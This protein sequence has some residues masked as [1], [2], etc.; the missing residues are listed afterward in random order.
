[1]SGIDLEVLSSRRGFNGA[2]RFIKKTLALAGGEVNLGDALSGVDDDL[3]GR[4]AL[5]LQVLLVEKLG[6]KTACRNLSSPAG[7]LRALG[8]VFARW[9]AVDL[10]AAYHHP[11]RGLLAANPKAP[12]ELAALGPLKKRELLVVY[13]GGAGAEEGL[14]ERAAELGA[15]LFDG[16]EIRVPE[17][18]CRG[19]FAA[20]GDGGG[21]ERPGREA[22]S[23]GPSRRTPL[24]PV[25]VG[26]D[27]FHN[28]NVE[29]WKRI[30]RSYQEKYPQSRVSVY[31][32]GEMILNI[33]ALFKWGK[34][35][36]GDS[37]AFAVTGRDIRN[38]AKLRRYLLRAAGPDFQV[39]LRGSPGVVPGLF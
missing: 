22:V 30:I 7:D 1:M 12:G 13:A 9:K 27:L 25:A 6:Y 28:G 17:E 29:A 3:E 24:Y 5:L 34:V 31:Y 26:N 37:I 35:K 32:R 4:G 33:N 11:E 19:P 36:H 21:R 23:W 16:G 18:L 39:F 20:P 2:V 38:L 14:C 10:A 8:E 15:A